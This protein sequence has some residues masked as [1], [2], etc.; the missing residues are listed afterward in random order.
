MPEL[1]R[2]PRVLF[3]G[4][5]RLSFDEAAR[6][7][8]G[9]SARGEAGVLA[10]VH[11]LSER[12]IYVTSTSALAAGARV[13]CRMFLGDE[14]RVLRGK[15][16]WVR[17]EAAPTP[18][19]ADSAAE[20][21]AG[22][23]FEEL[24]ERD[25]EVLRR[26]VAPTPD[27]ELPVQVWF[28][29]LGMPLE[30]KAVVGRD[31]IRLATALSYLKLGSTVRLA[32]ESRGVR[33]RRVGTLEAVALAPTQRGSAPELVISVSTAEPTSA[34]GVIDA[35]ESTPR[36][37]AVSAPVP[38]IVA[39][40]VRPAAPPPLPPADAVVA[41]TPSSPPPS[42]PLPAGGTRPVGGRAPAGGRTGSW[43]R[44]MLIRRAP[45]K[46]RG[47][48]PGLEGSASDRRRRAVV[49]GVAAAAG[50]LAILAVLRWTPSPRKGPPTE[51][52]VAHASRSATTA[53]ALAPDPVVA[54]A[55]GSDVEVEPLAGAA[56]PNPP[57]F[58][59]S[60]AGGKLVLTVPL[61]APASQVL[62]AV[63]TARGFLVQ[64]PAARAVAPGRFVVA[65]DGVLALAVE[66]RATGV[67]VRIE[68]NRALGPPLARPR[69]ERLELTFAVG[70]PAPR[71]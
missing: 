6:A 70:A 65:R 29:G 44:T 19:P 32:F 48:A 71:R 54:P 57:P 2:K 18:P 60:T 55:P 22:I 46:K 52:P 62:P 12:G 14:R 42:R 7:D 20:T 21:G 37:S 23:E 31:G 13:K 39:P 25:A 3:S 38:K 27:D 5:A 49:V 17:Q 35:G 4:S 53:A 11:N 51:R 1:R 47:G 67:A 26:L 68:T 41:R 36:A 69:G 16:A 45:T 24:S 33:E 15:I 64:V 30:C 43:E 40:E 8:A 61:T 10:R 34:Q 63:K 28:E 9:R 50:M 66:E 59:V 56:A 58:E